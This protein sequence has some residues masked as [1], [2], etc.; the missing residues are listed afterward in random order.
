MFLNVILTCLQVFGSGNTVLAKVGDKVITVEEFERKFKEVQQKAFNPPTKEEFLEDY[1]RYHIGLQ[2]AKRLNLQNDPV[3]RDQM[4]QALYRGLLEK[5]LGQKV[6]KIQISEAEMREYYKKNPE[7]RISH[8]LI[9]LKTDAN[10]AQRQE[11]WKRAQEIYKEVSSS[12]RPFAEL[13]KLYS[14]DPI[15]K[16]NGGDLG[17]Q[18]RATILPNVY[19]KLKEAKVGQILPPIE[20]PYG[21]HIFKKTDVRSYENADKR[22]LR[23]LVF[24]WKRKQ[25]F[26]Q[27]FQSLKVKYP[28]TINKAAF[29]P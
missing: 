10:D 21:V 14:D 25:I 2:E 17:F 3:V 1:I 6:E 9:S 5:F 16:S 22:Q 8:I 24:D 13:V 12:K 20:T 19:E 11:A 26:D 7:I 15:T 27:Y 29:K 28:I 23:A 4:E 18:S